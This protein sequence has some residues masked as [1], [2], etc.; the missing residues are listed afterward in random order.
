MRLENI[1]ISF[2]PRCIAGLHGLSLELKTGQILGVM[3]PSGAGK[4]T[5]LRVLSGELQPLKGTA[6][7]PERVALMELREHYAEDLATQDW[8]M[9]GVKRKIDPEKKLQLARDLAEAFEFPMQLKLRLSQLS[10][11]Q[12]QRA[13]LAYALID[14]PELL[15]LDEPFAHL[16]FPLRHEL[17]VLL[18]TYVKARDIT[19]VH[20]THDL[21]E[22]LRLSDK[23]GVL[24]FGKFEQLSTPQEVYWRPKNLLVAKL[25]GHLNFVTVSRPD[26]GGP[27]QTPFGPWN[28]AGEGLYKT[29][30]VLSLPPT[31]FETHPQGL[32]A[33]KVEEVQFLG[34]H[35]LVKV[36]GEGHSWLISWPGRKNPPQIAET[37]RFNVDLSRGVAID[38]L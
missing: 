37:C 5:L 27:W 11:G 3:G 15:L 33:G 21:E 34:F 36:K 29:H 18:K 22:A 35:W 20:V 30:L 9:A 2:D 7:L 23:L 38:C 28:S 6:H 14:H 4:S 32:W 1:F 12:R 13:R 8:L 31:A 10:E 25:M 17:M 24:H 16:D 19:V 26:P